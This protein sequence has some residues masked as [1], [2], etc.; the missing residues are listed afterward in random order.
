M[1]EAARLDTQELID[2]RPL[3]RF[4]YR[5]LALCAA[6][7]LMDG[8]DAQAIG[9]VA[10]SLV[11]QWHITRPA[12]GPVLSSGL[13]GMLMGALLFGTLGDRFGRRRILILCT[14]WFGAFSLLTARA[15]SVSSMLLLRLITG[16]G[17]GGTLP[18]AISLT[19]EYMP[20]RLRAT[21]VTLMFCGFPIGAAIVG[22]VAASL[23]PRF[24]WPA[25]FVVG[26]VL[27][28]IIAVFLLSLPE[29]IRFLLLKGEEDKRVAD[30]LRKIVP[31]IPIFPAAS[32]VL[33]ERRGS[34]F[35]VSQL[36]TQGRAGTTLLLW[37]IFF[38]SLVDVFFLNSWLPTV[39]HDAG[40]ALRQ[41]I[42]I[43]TC[44]QIGG[45]VGT[46][47]LGRFIDRQMSYRPL[48]WAYLGGAACVFWIGIA[49]GSVAIQSAAV[50]AAGFC[51]VG[52]QT[53]ANALAAEC[54]PTAIRSTGVGWALGIGRL[55]SI[56][57]PIVGGMLLSFEW[58]MRRVFWAAAVPALIAAAATLAITL[59]SRQ[60]TP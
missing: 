38:L 51:V 10:P 17:L 47:V 24:G 58:G 31:G 27:P 46:V 52:A 16:L 40:F 1:K 7:V 20:R 55:G 22:L 39:L 14:L 19:S 8:F 23:I 5:L 34:G 45:V 42:L 3:N 36:F 12:L 30:L 33:P 28:C 6:S 56:T 25:V 15:D 49:G 2:Q 21:G 37:A 26:G 13:A 41:A 32:F 11:E 59:K 60:S 44:F 50:F 4:Q 53:G 35:P 54:Y 48:A 57:G 9:F 29:S 43:T 18:N